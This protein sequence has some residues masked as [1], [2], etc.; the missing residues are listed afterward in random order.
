MALKARSQH[1]YAAAGAFLGATTTA[2]QA[3]ER[4]LPHSSLLKLK[5]SL[6][7]TDAALARLIGVSPRTLSRL[8]VKPRL[9]GSK[10]APEPAV[11]LDPVVSDRLF[12][13]AN[14]FVRARDLL[15]AEDAARDW[16]TTAQRGLGGLVPLDVAATEPGARDVE[17]LLHR[18][19]HGV[20]S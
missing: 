8:R 18:I 9:A 17:A 14:L 16:L 19:E 15:G 12:R 3:I 10:P 2:A 6:G 5:Q 13:F 20:Y 11:P 4:G 1:P 7:L